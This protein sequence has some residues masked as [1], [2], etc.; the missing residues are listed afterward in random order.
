MA[1]A[2]DTQSRAAMKVNHAVVDAGDRFVVCALHNGTHH[3]EP[4]GA[5]VSR[6]TSKVTSKF[7]RVAEKTKVTV[8]TKRRQFIARTRDKM[9]AE[10]HND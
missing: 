2:L 7:R 9:I 1:N 4:R 5:Y 3:K 6:E 8:S 10:G